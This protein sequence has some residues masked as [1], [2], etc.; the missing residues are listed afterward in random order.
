MWL[1]YDAKCLVIKMSPDEYLQGVIFFYTDLVLFT[2]FLGLLLACMCMGEGGVECG[3]GG[4]EA[5][6]GGAAIAIEG[7]GGAG[8]AYSGEGMFV[9][10]AGVGMDG[11]MTEDSRDV[12]GIPI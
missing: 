6:G 3:G 12:N 9:G 4:V 8:A 5:A 11:D 7:T 2:I 10:T 1:S